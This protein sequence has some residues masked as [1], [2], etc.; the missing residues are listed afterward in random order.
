MLDRDI[1]T[2]DAL[3]HLS[4]ADRGAH[5]LDRRRF[6][7]LI[8]M[9]AG[10]GLVGTGSTSLLDMITGHDPSTWAVGPVA[11]DQG[12]LVVIGLFGGNDGLNTVVPFTDGNYFDQHGVLAVP[13]DQTLVL[14]GQ[15]GLN[16]RLPEFK[17]WWDRGQLAIVEGVGYENPDQ[18]HFNSMAYWM[19]GRPHA[20]PTSGWVGR[21]LDGYLAGQTD[22]YAAAEVGQSVPLHLIGQQ[23]RGTGVPDQRPDW[24]S[25]FDTRSERNYQAVRA[26]RGA[27]GRWYDAVAQAAVDAI[28]VAGTVTPFVPDG[29]DLPPVEIVARMEVAARLINANLGFRV[30]TVGFGDFDSHAGQPTMHNA[31]MSELN[32]AVVRFFATLGPDWLPRVTLMTFS[33]FGRTSHANAGLGTDHGSSAP[34]FVFG[35]NVAGGF[36]GQ[37]PTLAGLGR[38][39]RMVHHVDFRSYYTS[40]IDGWLGGGAGTV[41]GGNFENLGIFSRAPGQLVDGSIATLPATPGS[42]STF[43]PIAPTRVADTRNGTPAG[44]IGT[45]QTLRVRVTGVGAV[46]AAG[47]TAIV[48]NVT[49]VDATQPHFF[50][51]F[52]GGAPRPVTSN[53]N[54][55][56]GRPV[57]NL[58]V[59]G[60]GSDGFIEVFNSHGSAHCLVDVFGYFTPSAGDRF[61]PLSPSRLFDTRTGHGV[62]PGKIGP[63]EVVDVAVAGLAGVPV[64]ARAVVLNLAATETDAPGY[65]ALTPTGQTPG[66]TSNINFFAGDTVANL[67]IVQLGPD[68]RLLLTGPGSGKHALADVFGYFGDVGDRFRAVSPRRLLDTREGLGAPLA[69][70]GPQRIIDVTVASRAGVPA[71]ATAVVLNVAATNVDAPSFIT[72]WPRGEP[73]PNTSNLNLAAGQTVANLV[74]CRLGANGGLTFRNELSE[75]DVLADVMGYYIP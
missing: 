19:A 4:T 46:P 54:G 6:L 58:V 31:R 57:P 71:N 61:T 1:S 33:E 51:V 59:M 72:V 50:T 10:A 41:L 68:G 26:M 52:P 24:G 23:Q 17:R 27:G 56:P 29:A 74:I 49:A 3:A 40:V 8:G 25:S 42:P 30:I 9:G 20:I 53:I 73:Q 43:V 35:A 44:M 16:S 62:R 45:E 66:G 18:S 65:L 67:V 37:R 14:D 2:R 69:R 28:D 38:W 5:S 7:Q 13:A 39:D 12:I 47:V 36:Y 21:W 64:G 63:A 48:A 15:S 34:Q 75:C 55:G 60:V 22:L 11:P 32:D 70:I